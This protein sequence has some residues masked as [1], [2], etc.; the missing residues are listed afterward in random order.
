M[1]RESIRFPDGQAVARALTRSR[2]TAG[3]VILRLAWDLGLSR[4]EICRLR[5]SDISFEEKSLLL[6][7]RRI[8]MPEETCQCLLDRREEYGGVSEY[9]VISDRLHRRMHPESVSRIARAALDTEPLLANIRLIDLRYGFLLRQIREHG[10][11]YA[12][13]V[14]GVQV[15]T[16][17]AVLL[18]AIKSA[19]L[20]AAIKEPPP[21]SAARRQ[22][23]RDIIQSEGNSPA[24]LALRMA[25]DLDMEVRE[26]IALTW[27]QIDFDRGLICLEDRSIPMDADLQQRLLSLSLSRSPDA[28]PHVLLTPRAMQPYDRFRISRAI[29]TALV[30]GGADATLQRHLRE[31]DDAALLR[32][33]KEHGSISWQEAAELFHMEKKQTNRRLLRLIKEKKLVRVGAKY[34]LYGT[35]VAPEDQYGVICDYLRVSGTAFRK[36]IADLLRIEARPCGQILHNLVRQGKL[37]KTGQHYSLPPEPENPDQ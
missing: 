4:D 27:E 19:G 31:N 18:P 10:W 35:V 11:P 33:V 20:G 9:V 25:W 34:Y 37:T 30:R 12:S 17:Q 7:D 2:K 26:S 8:P 6:P 28:D 23:L 16:M 13:R 32:Y 24:G 22:T 29:R 3:E 5:W 15:S 21:A 36:D 1:P 14:S